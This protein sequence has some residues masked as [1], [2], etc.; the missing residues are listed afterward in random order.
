VE[1]VEGAV[2]ENGRLYSLGRYPMLVEG[3]GGFVQ[4]ALLTMQAVGYDQVLARFDLLEGV[5]DDAKFCASSTAAYRRVQRRV[6]LENGRWTEA[7]VYL[8]QPSYVVGRPLIVNG[9]W[10]DYV[11]TQ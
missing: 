11:E 4:G 9:D 6:L 3:G 5:R 10:R 7:W 8:G 1:R 2:L